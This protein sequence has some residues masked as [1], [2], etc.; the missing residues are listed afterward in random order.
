M[1]PKLQTY[2]LR[3]MLSTPYG[4]FVWET[5]SNQTLPLSFKLSASPMILLHACSSSV[6]LE[7]SFLKLPCGKASS[8]SAYL[9]PVCIHCESC[10]LQWQA[11]FYCF[12]FLPA[13]QSSQSWEPAAKLGPFC[14]IINGTDFSLS[15]WLLWK[16]SGEN[17]SYL[18]TV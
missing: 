3:I 1:Q 9:P 5:S 14:C 11:S 16:P 6:C 8:Y 2:G 13:L 17:Q 15:W 7:F 4:R 10:W 12:L 18:N